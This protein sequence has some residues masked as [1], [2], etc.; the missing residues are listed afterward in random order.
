MRLTCKKHDVTL[1]QGSVSRIRPAVD[2]SLHE[3]CC[4]RKQ[5]LYLHHAAT[6][7]HQTPCLLHT[8]QGWLFSDTTCPP[9]MTRA[10]H[11]ALTAAD[12]LEV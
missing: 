5:A 11:Q 9:S 3:S 1:G 12:W 10:L 4:Q 2:C 7:W 6:A 8:P